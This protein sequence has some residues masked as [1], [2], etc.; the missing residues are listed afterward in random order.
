MKIMVS[1]SAYYTSKKSVAQV[2]ALMEKTYKKLVE[3]HKALEVPQSQSPAGPDSS[4]FH[5]TIGGMV[6]YVSNVPITEGMF[7]RQYKHF[8][9][10][11][12]GIRVD[13]RRAVIEEAHKVMNKLV[14]GIPLASV[15]HCPDGDVSF[16]DVHGSNWGGIGCYAVKRAQPGEDWYQKQIQLQSQSAE[17]VER[18]FVVKGSKDVVDRIAAFLGMLQFNGNIGHSGMFAL[19]WDGD[20]S[21]KAQISGIEEDIKRFQ[22]GYSEC[23][24]YGGDVEYMGALG[25]FGVMRVDSDRT[26]L[27]WTL[28]DGK[29]E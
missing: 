6:E 28:K 23:A 11:G 17:E 1:T 21:D 22:K 3:K 4:K 29:V 12:S 5:A 8:L 2:M 24:S 26:K 27:L 16:G 10:L 18:T 14:P 20:G 7:R 19:G 9:K 15:I 13:K 25:S